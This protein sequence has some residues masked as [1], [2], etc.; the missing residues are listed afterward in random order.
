MAVLNVGG[1]WRILH[2]GQS[3]G[4]EVLMDFLLDVL[5]ATAAGVLVVIVTRWFNRR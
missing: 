3:P 1:K 5:A 2:V 4:R